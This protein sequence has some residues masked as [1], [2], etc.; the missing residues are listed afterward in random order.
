MQVLPINQSSSGFKGTVGYSVKRKITKAMRGEIKHQKYIASENNRTLSQ[1]EINRIKEIYNNALK[2]LEEQMKLL[3]PDTRL[4]R[5]WGEFKITNPIARRSI[6]I[7][8]GESGY[9]DFDKKNGTLSMQSGS[10]M[11]I[12][13]HCIIN[14]LVDPIKVVDK[15]GINLWFFNQAGAELIKKIDNPKTRSSKK[16]KRQIVKINEYSDQCKLNVH[17]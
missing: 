6:T 17:L 3:H 7:I 11:D 15:D 16:T 9:G 4:I 14:R 13:F 1:A 10:Y 8:E 12:D 2:T 5:R